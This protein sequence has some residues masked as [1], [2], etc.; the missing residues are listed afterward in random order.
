MTVGS[1][2]ENPPRRMHAT[3]FYHCPCLTLVAAADVVRTW[4][5]DEFELMPQ[6]LTPPNTHPFTLLLGHETDVYPTFNPWWRMKYGEFAL[7]IPYVRLKNPGTR[8]PGPYLFTP[9]LYIDRTLPILLGQVMYGFAKVRAEMSFTDS[10][11]TVTQDKQTKFE[12]AFDYQRQALT[13]PQ[14]DIV[15]AVLQQPS[16][17]KLRGFNRLVASGFNW[18]L[19]Q[20]K[21]EAM[22]NQVQTAADFMPG[23]SSV[24]NGVKAQA[25]SADGALAKPAAYLVET[26]WTLTAPMSLNHDW[27]GYVS[28][29]ARRF[30]VPA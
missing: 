20:A 2:V 15:H 8:F 29:P 25:P 6:S 21:L 27:S 18:S 28:E 16:L 9:H 23:V 4:L 7:V 13:A 19:G 26:R 1:F 11:L 3:G 12:C 10:G 14:T 24:L 5:L 17:S 22:G 30:L